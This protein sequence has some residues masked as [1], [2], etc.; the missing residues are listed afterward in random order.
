MQW[1][2]IKT[3]FILCFLVL[4]VYLLFIFFDKQEDAD[5]GTPEQQTLKFDKQLENEN[6]TIS[7]DLPAKQLKESFIFVEQKTFG[8]EDQKILEAKENLK[9]VIIN[10][11]YIISMFKKPVPIAKDTTDGL[12]SQQVKKYILS[13]ENY[14]YWDWNKEM[15]VLV[16][17]QQK[18]DRPVYFNQNGIILVFLNEENEMIFYTQTM[19]GSIE[20]PGEPNQLIKPMQAIHAL[21]ENNRLE[22]GD[23]ITDVNIGFYTRFP[24][25]GGEQVFA[26]TWTITV[27]EKENFY[28]NAIENRVF[29]SDELKF[30]KDAAITAMNKARMLEEDHD[31]MKSYILE[32]IKQKL[33][34]IKSE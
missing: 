24:L 4:D 32:H 34:S 1:K 17:F 31:E 6:I 3:L 30:L 20:K 27:N 23:E 9:S 18:S 26:P 12:I 28:V 21:F 7:A 11:K 19:L 2:Q 22:S 10:D 15:N 29:S 5:L 8:K 16:L 25:E 33:A 13:P 14:M